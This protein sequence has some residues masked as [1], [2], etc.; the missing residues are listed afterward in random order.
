MDPTSVRSPLRR[1]L[2]LL[3]DAATYWRE[4]EATRCKGFQK[5]GKTST[6]AKSLAQTLAVVKH[7]YCHPNPFPI[8]TLRP[9]KRYFRSLF[10][11]LRGSKLMT[12]RNHRVLSRSCLNLAAFHLPRIEINSPASLNFSRF[13]VSAFVTS[14]LIHNRAFLASNVSKYFSK[15]QRLILA[16]TP[17][18]LPRIERPDDILCPSF[19]LTVYRRARELGACDVLHAVAIAA[20]NV[21]N[22]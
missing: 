18:L 20:H 5:R 16:V 11:K 9:T 2:V 6:S 3:R 22:R 19:I 12:Q 17:L 21:L 10:A 7:F 8:Y 1:R 13:F 15:A 4:W 14:P